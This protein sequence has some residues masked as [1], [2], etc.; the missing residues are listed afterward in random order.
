MRLLT[1]LFLGIVLFSSCN[2]DKVP[3]DSGNASVEPEN[4]VLFNAYFGNQ[5]LYLDSTYT[6]SDGNK[7]Q[8]TTLKCYFSEIKSGSGLLTNYSLYDLSNSAS[9]IIASSTILPSSDS[10]SIGIGVPST[11]NHADPSS[12]PSSNP[13][14]IMNA[15]DM[16]WDWNPGYIFIKIE[17]KADTIPDAILNTD[18]LLTYHI[19]LDS[20]YTTLNLNNANWQ[21]NG[22]AKQLKLKLDL[23][24]VFRKAGNEVNFSTEQTTHSAAGYEILTAKIRDNFNASIS[25]E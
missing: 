6:F 1:P 14:N 11:E 2:H 17:A 25:L 18:C 7:I 4:T 12:W 21:T 19:G 13:L 3:D 10:L 9:W 23:E 20:N 8:F 15:N 16:H 5:T 24:N 22:S